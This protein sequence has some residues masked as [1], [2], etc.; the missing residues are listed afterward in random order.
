MRGRSRGE[1]FIHRLSAKDMMHNGSEGNRG[2]LHMG[3]RLG[4]SAHT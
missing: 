3:H 2:K 1:P 4:M